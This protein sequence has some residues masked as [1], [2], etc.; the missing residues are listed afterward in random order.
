MK[1]RD[2][3]HRGMQNFGLVKSPDHSPGLA[4]QFLEQ[5]RAGVLGEFGNRPVPSSHRST[6]R[7]SSMEQRSEMLAFARRGFRPDNKT[8][9]EK[10][11]MRPKKSIWAGRRRSDDDPWQQTQTRGTDRI[12]GFSVIDSN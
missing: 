5:A 8:R 6:R 10:R 11:N 2:L 9:A 3:L 12:R 1:Q 7:R 4:Q